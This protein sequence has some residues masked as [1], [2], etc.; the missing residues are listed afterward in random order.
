LP[1]GKQRI[2]IQRVERPSG[3]AVPVERTERKTTE[4]LRLSLSIYSI[5]MDLLF[6]YTIA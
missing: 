1:I 6:L 3:G 5:Y 2:A 4:K